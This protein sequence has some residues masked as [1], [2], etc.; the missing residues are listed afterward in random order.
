MELDE[1]DKGDDRNIDDG[2]REGTKA[3]AKATVK[4]NSVL[5]TQNTGPDRRACCGAMCEIKRTS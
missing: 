3:K 2:E 1:G 4:A 5:K